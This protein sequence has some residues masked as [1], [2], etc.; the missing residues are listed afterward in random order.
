LGAVEDAAAQLD[1]LERRLAA[2]SATIAHVRARPGL[3][4][5]DVEKAALDEQARR[6]GD[7]TRYF[8]MSM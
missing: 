6:V 3:G 8:L 7:A 1:E 4:L 2:L 5:S